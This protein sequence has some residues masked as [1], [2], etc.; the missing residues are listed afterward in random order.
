MQNRIIE[1]WGAVGSYSLSLPESRAGIRNV[2]FGSNLLKACFL[3]LTYT[4]SANGLFIFFACPKKTNQKKRQPACSKTHYAFDCCSHPKLALMGLKQG[5]SRAR[6]SCKWGQRHDRCLLRRTMA[7]TNAKL[8]R[9]TKN[10]R[11]AGY[12]GKSTRLCFTVLKCF[13]FGKYIFALFA[14]MLLLSLTGNAQPLSELIETAR[15]N[16]PALKALQQEYAAA[17]EVAP[18]VSQLPDTEFGAGA[19]VAPVETRLGGQRARLS[20]SQMFPW[21]GTLKT[22]EQLALA[23]AAA[24][25][26][27]VDAEA[28][29]MI[30]QLRKAYFQLYEWEAS[31]GILKKNLRILEAL[32]Q[33]TLAKVESGKASTADVLRVELKIREL[34]QELQILETQRQKPLATINQVLNRPANSPVQAPDTLAFSV[35]PFEKDSLFQQIREQHPS[36]R[37][38]SLQQVAARQ[39]ITLNELER[40][41]SFGVGIDYIMVSPRS[42]AEPAN[43]GRDIWQAGAKVQVPL[44]GE[45][46]A[47]KEREEKL[48]I[49][50]LDNRKADLS[51]RIW[52]NIE[53]AY[54]EYETARLRMELYAQQLQTLKRAVDILQTQYSTEGSS[55]D[56]LLQLEKER[57]DYELKMMKA[58]VQSWM[59]RVEVERYWN[60]EMRI[61]KSE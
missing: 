34:Q 7:R 8:T 42:D 15:Q 22:R 17:L 59:A 27:K 21:F 12:R 43:N 26:E 58:V 28:L 5:C 1:T 52:A 61:R 16:N 19:F 3:F 25:R 13:P 46:Y 11:L 57:V 41:P 44:F 36:L 55:F 50:A 6:S 14:L 4:S 10:P 18:Q 35:L 32:Q 33:L 45:K 24:V 38:L 40:K 53:Q 2:K 49:A 39:A 48:K 31:Q 60:S 37:Q 54:A 56:E 9:K 29:E 51:A 47:A 20:A 30:Y 23:N